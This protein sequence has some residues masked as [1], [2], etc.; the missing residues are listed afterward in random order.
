MG[1]KEIKAGRLSKDTCEQII[2]DVG[3]KSHPAHHMKRKSLV[4]IPFRENEE[5][6]STPIFMTF[7]CIRCGAKTESYYCRF[8]KDAV[9]HR[10]ICKGCKEQVF[11]QFFPCP[12]PECNLRMKCLG[13][14][15]CEV[16]NIHAKW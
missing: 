10:A 5:R 4:G 15:Q 14:P 8:G 13:W 16:I 9:C 2:G 7:I 11:H 1:A 12:Y 3:I 6:I